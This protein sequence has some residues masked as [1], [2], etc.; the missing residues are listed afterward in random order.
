MKIPGWK[1]PVVL[2]VCAGMSVALAACTGSKSKGGTGGGGSGT[3][4]A[5][6]GP[7]TGATKSTG[8]SGP[9]KSGGGRT[10]TSGAVYSAANAKIVNPSTKAGG[11]LRF[12]S[13]DEPDS[14][15]PGDTYYAWMWDFSRLYGRALMSFKPGPGK[16]GLQLTPDLATAPGKVSS[17]GMTW[18]YHIKSGVKFED[19]TP[20][21]TKDIKY[22]VERSNYAKDVLPN[23]P[24][25]FATYLKDPKYPGP[26]KD[27]AKD[28][29]GLTS[30]DTPN[31]TT[32]IF[33]LAQPFSDFDYLATSPQTFP[34]PPGKDTGAKYREHPVSTGPYKFSGYSEGK[35]FALVRNKYWS[36]KADPLRAALP[37]KITVQYHVNADDLD[38]KLMSGNL[39]VDSAGT[40][41]QAAARAQ[42]L[43]PGSKYKN[44]SDDALSGF[45]WFIYI[46][47]KIK[48]LD[49]VHCRRAVEYAANKT[50]MQTAYGGPVAGGDIAST[51]MPPNVS[52]YQKFDLYEATTKPT[53]DQEMAKKELKACGQPN[54]F[55]TNISIRGDRPKE[56]ASSQA[57]QQALSK[58]GIK[59]SIQKYPAGKYFK[60][61]AGNLSFSHSHDLGLMYGGWAADW[62]TGFGFLSQIIDG[63]A[64]KPAGNNNLSE[65]NSPAINGMLDKT[66]RLTSIA[67]RNKIYGQLDKMVMQDGYF[68]PEVYAKSLLYRPKNL[69]NVYVTQAYGMYDY[70]QL[71]VT[72]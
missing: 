11:T 62:P 24:S 36:N 46:G 18:T 43:S 35:G 4:T 31:D 47:S 2:V 65:I 33:H 39:D 60:N 70:T 66:S 67:A 22:A 5:T 29:L 48:P 68:L 53:G 49:N 14:T 34:V 71:G 13:S 58:V 16:A 15:D 6:A 9:T 12:A 37:D 30:V 3:A 52:G 40:G 26:Y 44:D 50:D 32:I 54:G 51:V 23:G 10:Q 42:I 56:V 69:T 59:T 45:T 17:D 64:I 63:R 27:K 25:Y 1:K 72:K 19:G 20:V 57:L 8:P 61:F 55:S 41:V 28:K 7:S 21:T 38:Q